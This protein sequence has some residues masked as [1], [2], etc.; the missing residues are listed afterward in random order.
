MAPSP[1]DHRKSTSRARN[2]SSTKDAP[3]SPLTAKQTMVFRYIVD[4]SNAMGYPPTQKEIAAH[5]P[6]PSPGG[7]SQQSIAFH[8][9]N[10]EKKGFIRTT[11]TARGIQILEH[12]QLPWLDLSRGE[13]EEPLL[14]PAH[15]LGHAPQALCDCFE[16]AD[17]LVLIHSDATRVPGARRNDWLAVSTDTA[18]ATG[19]LVI[20]SSPQ[21]W[22]C[23]PFRQGE[24]PQHI[25]GVIIGLLGPRNLPAEE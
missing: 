7:R 4:F 2:P 6:G 17:C 14:S 1:S 13:P 3:T 21:G 10:L 19:D 9:R 18:P 20:E 16:G 11:G 5:C 12:D 22:R 24:S 23:R 15:T 25:A 8:I